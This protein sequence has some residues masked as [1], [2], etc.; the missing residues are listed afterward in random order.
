MIL[1]DKGTQ[2]YVV[3]GYIDVKDKD[4]IKYLEDRGFK[5]IKEKKGDK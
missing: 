5:Q 3:K 4:D 1:T 2:A